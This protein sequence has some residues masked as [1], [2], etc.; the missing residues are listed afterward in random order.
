MTDHSDK[1]PRYYRKSAVP[2]DSARAQDSARSRVEDSKPDSGNAANDNSRA[3]RPLPA[4]EPSPKKKTGRKNRMRK[5]RRKFARRVTA[6]ALLLALAALIVCLIIRYTPTSKRMS[7][8][9]YF[10]ELPEGEV[11]VVLQDSIA[12]DHALLK[13]GNLYIDYDTVRDH[14]NSRFY[15]DEDN[16]QM[17][18]TTADSIYEIPVGS[19]DYKIGLEDEHYDREIVLQ[20]A[21]GDGGLYLDA[22]FL[23]QYTDVEYTWKEG[24]KHMLLRYEFGDT[25]VAYS[26]KEAEVR[27]EPSI[28]SPILTDLD[29]GERVYVLWDDG[30]TA[31]TYQSQK[32]AADSASGTSAD[33]AS[34]T[35]SQALSGETE[36]GADGNAADGSA[37]D[38][39]AAD[40]SA[41]LDDSAGT[42]EADLLREFYSGRKWLRVLSDDGCIGYVRKNRLNEIKNETISTGFVPQEY[43]SLTSSEPINLV[44]HQLSQKSDNDNFDSLTKNMSGVD[45]ISPTWFSL[46]TNDGGLKS[47]GSRDYVKKAHKKG[48]K[49]WGLLDDFSS[50]MD[51]SVVLAS[52]VARRNVI[53]QLMNYADDLDLDGINLDFEYQDEADGLSYVQFVRELSIACRERKLV[54]S[55]DVKVPYD[56]NYWYNRKEL[57]TV[58]DY[59]VIMGYDEHYSGSASS[60][61]VASLSFE[62]RGIAET[63][64]QGV[65]AGKILSGI[66]FYTRIWYTSPLD[67]GGYSISSEVLSMGSAA[68]TLKTYGVQTVWDADA[69]QNYADW[70]LDNGVR[71]EIWMEDSDSIAAKAALASEYETGGLAAWRLGF[72]SDDIWKVMKH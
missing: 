47:I 15:W 24:W 64:R 11:A 34:G 26:S 25:P 17:L 59:V 42:S 72:E 56:F 49:V 67:S 55:V 57:G 51:T 1:I 7:E 21:G 61:S 52:T 45:V 31:E 37:A 46:T 35:A 12:G 18:Y 20:N 3:D 50:D 14:L 6:L 32:A 54:L 53:S 71:C 66:P 9:E 65:P 23:K 38:S 8:S 30:L 13:D 40:S 22:A 5:R 62:R 68:T 69:G 10:G 44:W 36:G 4:D 27:Y 16:A 28:K 58:C 19:A 43:P 39:T 33:G 70:T 2:G 60:G 48:L 29:K 41:A 63:I